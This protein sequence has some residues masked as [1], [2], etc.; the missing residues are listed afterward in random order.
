MLLTV[1]PVCA[2]WCLTCVM[3]ELC[4]PGHCLRLPHRLIAI[5]G[6]AES[7]GADECADV[8]ALGI[9]VSPLDLPLI[10]RDLPLGWPRGGHGRS[11]EI[12]ERLSGDENM[13]KASMSAHSPAP[14]DIHT[15]GNRYEA[16]RQSQ[17]VSSS[18]LT[19]LDEALRSSHGSHDQTQ[20]HVYKNTLSSW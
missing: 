19:P 20:A 15:A 6:C 16:M 17:T 13:R 4:A 11:R 14:G 8:L 18:A 9:F 12:K 3:S 1:G 10:S 5:P 2:R 7:P